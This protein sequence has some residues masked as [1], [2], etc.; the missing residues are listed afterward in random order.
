MTNN[1]ELNYNANYQSLQTAPNQNYVAVPNYVPN[2]GSAS[3]RLINTKMVR[4]RMEK[5]FA[6]NFNSCTK[7]YFAV[8]TIS[9][10][11]DNN[12]QNE[13]ETPLFEAELHIPFCCPEPMKFE[14]I[15]A[16]T[17]QVFSTSRNNDNGKRV[18]SCC[19]FGENYYIFPDIFHSKTS[20]PNDFSVT[21]CYD[22][23]SF[24]RTFEYQGGVFYKLGKPY[25]PVDKKC[26]DCDCCC[27]CC[28]K[29]E[30]EIVVKEESCC[31]CCDE[32]CKKAQ[33]Q[34]R[35]YVDIFNMSNQSVGKYVRYYD[36]SGCLCC[37][38]TTYFFE[39]YFPS[40]ANEMLKLSL[41][42]HLIFLL[43]VGTN[44]FSTLPGSEG[45]LALFLNDI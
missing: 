40:D 16:Q 42:G 27:C 18:Y 25:V 28:C 12:H 10:I 26:C 11:D 15:D 23:R 6:C 7:P 1:N 5:K 17:K 30:E 4:I 38:S 13:N 22:S 45:N 35:T 41:I 9:R 31:S 14:F 19:C 20:N 33:Y 8:N 43:Q 21:K 2:D 3:S 39:I 24:Y 32:C 34:K 29:K 44:I 36:E 37:Q